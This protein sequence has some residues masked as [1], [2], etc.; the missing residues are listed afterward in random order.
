MTNPVPPRRRIRSRWST[1]L[2]V[3]LIAALV[4]GGVLAIRSL[5]KSG[6][7]ASP[8][9]GVGC[10]TSPLPSLAARETAAPAALPE[11]S[12]TVPSPR[13]GAMMAYDPI[14]GYVLLFGGSTG[15]NQTWA[16]Q[17][18]YWTELH[19]KVSPPAMTFGTLVY[20]P[21][22][23]YQVLF[24]GQTG[25]PGNASTLNETWTYVHGVWDQLHPAHSPPSRHWAS[26]AYDSS[27]GD[28]LLFGGAHNNSDLYLG[29]TWTFAN[30]TWVEQ[31][32]AV[33]PYPR[34]GATMVDD[35]A[36]GYVLLYGGETDAVP[37][38]YYA[39][40]TW[41]YHG[42]TWTELPEA[43]TPP[44]RLW[45]SA[46]FD[47][48]TGSVVVFGGQANH[49]KAYNSTQ[50]AT[51]EFSG[52]TWTNVTHSPSPPARFG[53]AFS[54]DPPYGSLILFGGLSATVVDATVLSDTWTYGQ[55][56]WTLVLSGS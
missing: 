1:A 39:N 21:S 3:V 46:A 11:S 51:W 45:D 22:A 12:D 30:G 54:Y 47:C 14:D 27:D 5:P 49:Y 52:G 55:G 8:P 48:V 4:V 31:T 33:S 17:G 35:P 9:S 40:D 20:D 32:P 6:A 26:M 37:G 41:I 38:G 43:H 19:P 56:H 16:Y 18:G 25:G 2:G 24:G 7:P 44:G 42:R 50:N 13:W 10:V 29:D 53:A 36:D 15:G 23:G 34:Y 28:I